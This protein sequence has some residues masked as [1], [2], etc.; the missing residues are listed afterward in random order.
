MTDQCMGGCMSRQI[1]CDRM[2][3]KGKKAKAQTRPT[4]L[5]LTS[6][7]LKTDASGGARLVL[8]QLIFYPFAHWIVRCTGIDDLVRPK[9]QLSQTRPVS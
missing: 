7:V 6:R 2:F 9:K 5:F 4:M 8:T 1:D 3:G